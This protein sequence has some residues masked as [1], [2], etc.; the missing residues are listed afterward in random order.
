MHA[1][2][3]IVFWF[4][5]Q[6]FHSIVKDGL[7]QPHLYDVLLYYS[8]VLLYYVIPQGEL[9]LYGYSVLSMTAKTLLI[10]PL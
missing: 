4:L 7:I 10:S 1:F 6:K 2:M 9:N 3:G 5:D 8:I